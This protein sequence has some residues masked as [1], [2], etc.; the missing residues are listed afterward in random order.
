MIGQIQAVR[1]TQELLVLH[2]DMLLSECQTL[3]GA[4]FILW[5][6]L[7]SNFLQNY[8]S[9]QAYKVSNL[10]ILVSIRDQANVS[11]QTEAHSTQTLS[12]R[13]D[14]DISFSA[15]VN[16][17]T[18]SLTSILSDAFYKLVDQNKYIQSLQQS[19]DPAF[20]HVHFVL[21]SPASSSSTRSTGIS[22]RNIILMTSSI[23]GGIVLFIVTAL[24]YRMIR[25]SKN[26]KIKLTVSFSTDMENKS[27]SSAGDIIVME[28]SMNH[29]IS[30][31]GAD[32]W[33][34]A[35]LDKRS[36]VDKDDEISMDHCSVDYDFFNQLFDEQYMSSQHSVLTND[37]SL[38]NLY[39][40]HVEMIAIVAPAG[41]LGMIVDT[42]SHGVPT[43]YSVKD[44]SPL[45]N[46]V[47]V[48]DKLI[49][50]NN[51]DTTDMTAFQVSKL[52]M[53]LRD[54]KRVLVLLRSIECSSVG[55]TR[56]SA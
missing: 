24:I 3:T 39:N 51:I 12:I 27:N 45:I 50:I 31:L 1:R 34:R 33:D 22:K 52:I 46:K 44:S 36:S 25:K 28:A 42:A 21:V 8:A 11:H 47:L 17:T 35:S 49:S 48:G 7:T 18:H 38:T 15:F 43:I 16:E 53:K 10:H 30:T 9:E 14:A 19:N 37:S 41:L 56:C 40:D 4:S 5:Q 29:D 13:F 54:Q 26:D 2:A 6:D 32:T 23:G 20:D 55:G